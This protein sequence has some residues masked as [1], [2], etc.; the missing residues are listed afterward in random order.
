M[1]SSC[2]GHRQ[3]NHH[4]SGSPPNHHSPN[5]QTSLA[6]VKRR[7]LMD[8]GDIHLMGRRVTEALCGQRGLQELFKDKRSEIAFLLSRDH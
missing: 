7:K 2:P 1:L 8:S 4:F 5:I 3:K 6:V